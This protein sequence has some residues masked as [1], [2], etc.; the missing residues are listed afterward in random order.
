MNIYDSKYPKIDT[1][2]S[3]YKVFALIESHSDDEGSSYSGYI[4]V[5]LPTDSIGS[6][7]AQWIH[8]SKDGKIEKATQQDIENILLKPV[9][10]FY[11]Q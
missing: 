5:T 7:K 4:K 9:M 6:T 11:K 3:C 1:D 2:D 8:I 10:L